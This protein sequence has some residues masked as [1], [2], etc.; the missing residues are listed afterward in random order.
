MATANL[1]CLS[2]D[3]VV[4]AC[5]KCLLLHRKMHRFQLRLITSQSLCDGFALL[6]MFV[7]MGK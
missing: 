7:L 2:F 6:H 5:S 3:V 4:R 1:Q